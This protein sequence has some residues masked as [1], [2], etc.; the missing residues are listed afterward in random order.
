MNKK[1]IKKILILIFP[2]FLTG[3]LGEAWKGYITKECKKIETING[4]K[5]ETNIKIKCMKKII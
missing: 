4:N 5:I 1:I 2:I 3:C